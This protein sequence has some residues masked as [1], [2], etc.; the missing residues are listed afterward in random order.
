MRTPSSQDI[1]RETLANLTGRNPHYSLRAFARDLAVSP[2]F[3][4]EVI[5]G[6]HRISRKRGLEL[7]ERLPAAASTKQNFRSVVELENAKTTCERK[8]WQDALRGHAQPSALDLEKFKVISN[9]DFLCLAELP[10]LRGFQNCLQWMADRLGMSAHTVRD[11]VQRLIRIGLMT[12]QKGGAVSVSN[13]TLTCESSIPNTFIRSLHR[14][15]LHR[16]ERALS[17]QPIGERRFDTLVLAVDRRRL[18]EAFAR[19]QTFCHEFDREFAANP[20]D[21]IYVLNVGLYRAS[22]VPAMNSDPIDPQN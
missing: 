17:Q 10:K 7:A 15:S 5:N 8:K 2:S 4:S 21:E 11:G 16:A 20:G 1:L 22:T 3:L 9:L 14:Q 12:Q 19:L 13:E 18:P 6:R